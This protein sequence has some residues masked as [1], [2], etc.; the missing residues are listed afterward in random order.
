MHGRQRVPKARSALTP[1][2]CSDTAPSRL[3]RSSL[4]RLLLLSDPPRLQIAC[5]VLSRA[6]PPIRQVRRMAFIR[7]LRIVAPALI[8]MSLGY[9]PASQASAQ[10]PRVLDAG[11]RVRVRLERN[12]VRVVGFIAEVRPDTLVLARPAIQS[13]RRTPLAVSDI[14]ELEVSAGHHRLTALGLAVGAVTGLA[15]TAAY[16]S[17]VQSQCFSGCPDRVSIGIGAAVGGI[18]VGGGFYFIRV[19]RWL[20]IAVPAPRDPGR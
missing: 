5:S 20:P 9:P 11:T 10:T 2:S 4:N 8:L 1:C 13:G 15:L 7:R 18:A 3:G 19:E 6:F 14:A 16:N 17:I 12:P